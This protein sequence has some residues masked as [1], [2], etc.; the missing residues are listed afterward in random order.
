MMS[1]LAT[2]SKN[3]FTFHPSSLLTLFSKIKLLKDLAFSFNNQPSL[4]KAKFNPQTSF[5]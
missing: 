4:T 2:P 3:A 1:N 5:A